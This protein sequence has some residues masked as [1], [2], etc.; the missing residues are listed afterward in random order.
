MEPAGTAGGAE[1]RSLKVEALTRELEEERHERRNLLALDHL[2]DV[3][4]GAS[5]ARQLLDDAARGLVPAFADWCTL[6]HVP[7]H[8]EARQLAVAAGDPLL[9]PWVEQ[10][11]AC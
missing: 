4:L 3:V 9:A 7:D 2:T 6:H 10:L 1:L 8:G 11:S 5:D